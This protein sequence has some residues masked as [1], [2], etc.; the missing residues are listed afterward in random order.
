MTEN[1]AFKEEKE[2]VLR[3]LHDVRRR[4]SS[5]FNDEQ[6]SLSDN[7]LTA[8]TAYIGIVLTFASNIR[9]YLG[10]LSWIIVA[11]V[12]SFTVSIIPWVVE[13]IVSSI[14]NQKIIKT[15]KVL[16]DVVNSSA[17]DSKTLDF[18]DEVAARLLSGGMTS[19]IPI[20]LQITAFIVGIIFVAIAI[21]VALM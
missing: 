13:K 15:S 21:V 12:V 16:A 8:A 10:G 3:G 2:R 19:S 20:I 17:N 18:A 6:R 7:L 14:A 1:D 5:D 4:S 9:G 11:S